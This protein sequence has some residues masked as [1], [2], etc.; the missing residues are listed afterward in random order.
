MKKIL[1]LLLALAMVMSLA[2][3]GSK[4]EA[5]TEA[6]A[7]EAPATEAPATE[8]PATEA[9]AAEAPAAVIGKVALVTDVG[10]IDD[11][12]FNQA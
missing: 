1:A 10:T 4:T 7:T 2:A 9:P 3:C 12:S 5:P 11:E 6:P 8:A